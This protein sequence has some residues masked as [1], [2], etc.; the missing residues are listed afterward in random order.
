MEFLGQLQYD[1]LWKGGSE[2]DLVVQCSQREL[3]CTTWEGS[4]GTRATSFSPVSTKAS[5]SSSQ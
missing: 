3:Y 4:N 2:W 1:F 5:H